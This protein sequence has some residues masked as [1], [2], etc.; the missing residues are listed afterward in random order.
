M[1][2]LAISASHKKPSSTEVWGRRGELL[3]FASPDTDYASGIV[4]STDGL[5]IVTGLESC[6]ALHTKKCQSSPTSVCKIK[7]ADKSVT[8]IKM[9]EPPKPATGV[10]KKIP[11]VVDG[12]HAPVLYFEEASNFRHT[13]GIIN[14]SLATYRSFPDGPE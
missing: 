7:R 13:N 8:E 6:D 2:T 12:Q 1:F 11:P 3:L 14:I 4:Q 9:A 10:E 5:K